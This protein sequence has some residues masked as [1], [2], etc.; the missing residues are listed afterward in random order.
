MAIS[1]M[2]NPI[3]PLGGT[4]LHERASTGAVTTTDATETDIA[5]IPV[6]EGE[7]VSVDVT[8]TARRSTGAEH[9]KWQLSGLF[10]RNSGGNVTIEGIVQ[11]VATH[12]SAASS[13]AVDMVADTSNQT[14][15][16]RVT[17]EAAKTIN[18]T[19]KVNYTSET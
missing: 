14:I 18:W 10:Y 7:T 2:T 4:G 12:Q 8:I 15:D 9:G 6:A 1:N 16:I 17:G 19:A 13:A 5:T 11:D 3:F